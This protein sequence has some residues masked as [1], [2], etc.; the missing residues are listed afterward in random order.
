MV[1]LF[2]LLF[3]IPY[4][5]F[6]SVVASVDSTNVELG[7]MVTYSLKIS[8][9]DIARPNIQRLCD[10]DVIST[11]SQTSINMINGNVQKNFV[12][13]YKFIP[14]KSCEIPPLEV[15]IGGKKEYSNAVSLKVGPVTGAKDK[16]FVLEMSSDKKSVYVG[17][18]FNVKLLFRQK[19]GVAAMDSEFIAPK[20]EGFWVKNE[21]KPKRYEDGSYVV[22]EIIYTLSAQ[23]EGAREIEKAQ[24]RI[25][26]RSHS[27]DSWGA[28]IPKIKWKTYFSNSL[29]LDV[30]AL[31]GGV[32]LVGDFSINAKVDKTSIEPGGAVNVT[33]E[34][35]GDGNLEDIK[36]FKP[37]FVDANIFDEKIK[38]KGNELTQ[39]MAFVAENDFV[40]PA[41][42]LEYLDLKTKEIKTISTKEIAI[43]VKN[44]KPKEELKIKRQESEPKSTPAP[45][46]HSQ[47]IDINTTV[48]IE[49]FLLGLVIGL[50]TMYFKPWSVFSIKSKS[51]SIKD[52]KTLLVKLLPYK[53]YKEVKLILDTIENNLYS[54]E[55][56]KIDKKQLQELL[57]KYNIS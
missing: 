38:I 53:D 20:L 57:E 52:E 56:K 44:S 26:S 43:K 51:V 15:E 40:I 21:S 11:S 1:K 50:A 39:K 28:W 33:I 37:D 12:L 32:S 36:S 10:T 22:S 49:V 30:K 55:K 14:Q 19:K 16:D 46:L 34:V 7:E 31:P 23:R 2:L 47:T 18:T 9:E 35:V 25:A 3:L 24:M 5:V 29:N 48:M 13:S 17:E 45:M 4:G 41:F 6:A 8:G 54:K 42:K 27:R